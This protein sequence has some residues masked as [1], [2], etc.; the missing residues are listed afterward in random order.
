MSQK[1]LGSGY[2]AGQCSKLD[3]GL[4]VIGGTV[5]EVR[6]EQLPEARNPRRAA[7]RPRRGGRQPGA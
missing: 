6:V 2:F 5:I 1:V 7:C 4:P 3:I